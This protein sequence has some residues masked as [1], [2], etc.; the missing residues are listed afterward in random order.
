MN[1]TYNLMDYM[2]ARAQRQPNPR[3][4]MVGMADCD[5]TFVVGEMV[6]DGF[7]MNAALRYLPYRYFPLALGQL[8]EIRQQTSNYRARWLVAPLDVTVAIPS[9]GSLDMTQR[10]N[11]GSILYGYNFAAVDGVVSDFEVNITE[12][13]N[14]EQ[15]F[16]QTVD[17]TCLRPTPAAA[18]GTDLF[19]V[20]FEPRE[21]WGNPQ[22]QLKIVITNKASSAQ[23]CQLLI[24]LTEPC[25]AQ[26]PGSGPLAPFPWDQP[27]VRG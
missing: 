22:P 18:Q 17:A 27:Q 1:R 6:A 11:N 12:I 26:G 4:R 24:H 21:L 16:D 3:N 9:F 13:C 10:V 19:P 23:R 5:Q 8:D 25:N 14:Q 15:Q 7:S 20:L 2:R